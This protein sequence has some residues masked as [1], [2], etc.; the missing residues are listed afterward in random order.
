[1][2]MLTWQPVCAGPYRLQVVLSA[3]LSV[4][5][6]RHQVRLVGPEVVPRRVLRPALAAARTVLKLDTRTPAVAGEGL[7]VP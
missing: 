4:D 5:L 1:M 7:P 3:V 2:R 6:V